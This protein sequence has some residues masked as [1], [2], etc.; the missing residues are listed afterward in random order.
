[1][2]GPANRKA[3]SSR[4]TNEKILA[5]ILTFGVHLTTNAAAKDL[6][7]L[8]D[9]LCVGSQGKAD[10]VEKMVLAQGGKRLPQS[11]VDADPVGAKNGGRAFSLKFNSERY[12]IMITEPGGCGILSQTSNADEVRSGLVKLYE[13]KKIDVDSSGPQ[14]VTTWK[15]NGPAGSERGGFSLNV[16]KPGFGADGALSLGYIPPGFMK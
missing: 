12:F 15:I 13:L 11:F 1:M 14:V 6:L 4:I 10:V 8:I 16:V 5:V 9:S 3:A 2:A 7:V